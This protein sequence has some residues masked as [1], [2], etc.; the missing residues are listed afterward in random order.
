MMKNK[1][2][3]RKEAEIEYISEEQ[4][5]EDVGLTISTDIE[6]AESGS[7]CFLQYLIPIRFP[8]PTST[9]QKIQCLLR[10]HFQEDRLLA[11]F[12]HD[13]PW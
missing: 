7:F 10:C 8:S 11:S 2:Q 9:N 3:G 4:K 12:D 1:G 5:T 6:S 13:F